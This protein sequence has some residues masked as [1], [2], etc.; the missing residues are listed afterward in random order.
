MKE[1]L[2]RMVV[3]GLLVS[4]FALFG[5][6]FKPKRFAGLLTWIVLGGSAIAWLIVAVS[7]WMTCERT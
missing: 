5:D 6:V 2:F 7:M 1:L 4:A 3:G